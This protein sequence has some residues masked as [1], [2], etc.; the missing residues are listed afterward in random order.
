[1]H[2]AKKSVLLRHFAQRRN[3]FCSGRSGNASVTFLNNLS[4]CTKMATVSRGCDVTSL[5]VLTGRGYLLM[6]RFSL[7]SRESIMLTLSAPLSVTA[8][9]M[10]K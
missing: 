1:M 9:E 5:N 8:N 7:S 10:I 3:E 6:A 4:T 2:I